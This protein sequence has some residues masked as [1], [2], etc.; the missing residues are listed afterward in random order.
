MMKEYVDLLSEKRLLVYGYQQQGGVQTFKTTEKGLRFLEIY[1]RLND[2]I[3]EEGTTI[4]LLPAFEEAE[5]VK[6]EAD[7]HISLKEEGINQKRG[8]IVRVWVVALV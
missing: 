3:K 2:M 7:Q 5:A 4:V 1:N 6:G 8:H